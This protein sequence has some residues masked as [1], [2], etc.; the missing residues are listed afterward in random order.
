MATVGLV[1]W[2]LASYEYLLAA[3]SHRSLAR[4]R[5]ARLPALRF[6]RSRERAGA[7]TN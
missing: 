3:A 4:Y 5:R 7:L 2:T 6:A 1:L